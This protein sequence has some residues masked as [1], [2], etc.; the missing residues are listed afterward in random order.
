[1]LLQAVLEK[2]ERKEGRGVKGNMEFARKRIITSIT[3][4]IY[5]AK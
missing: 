5:H 4:N 3:C 2:K 1:L